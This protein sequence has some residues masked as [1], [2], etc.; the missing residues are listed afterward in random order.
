ML[1]R[2]IINIF[3]QVKLRSH[4]V[5][6][7]IRLHFS[8]GSQL[9]L[10]RRLSMALHSS[11]PTLTPGIPTWGQGSLDE[12]I[13]SNATTF[14]FLDL[15]SSGSKGMGCKEGEATPCLWRMSNFVLFLYLLF[16]LVKAI[17]SVPGQNGSVYLSNYLKKSVFTVKGQV[18]LH[19][20]FSSPLVIYLET[21]FIQLPK[22]IKT[23]AHREVSA[24]VELYFKGCWSPGHIHVEP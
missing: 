24:Q 13:L 14:S 11:A 22:A 23:Q 7:W 18:V 15:S 16:N 20:S 9:I 3:D 5:L 12:E 2:N 6:E 4:E 17:L 21:I 8:V 1:K 19:K 10:Q